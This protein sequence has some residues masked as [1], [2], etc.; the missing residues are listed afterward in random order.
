MSV[1]QLPMNKNKTNLDRACQVFGWGGGTIHEVARQ[2]GIPGRGNDLT[3]MPPDEFERL[4]RAYFNCK[5][6]R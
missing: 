4:L 3:I 1:N 5:G 2:V 6:S